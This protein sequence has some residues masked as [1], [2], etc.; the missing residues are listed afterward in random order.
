MWDVDTNKQ[1][2]EMEMKNMIKAANQ[3]SRW[4]LMDVRIVDNYGCGLYHV[5]TTGVLE[6]NTLRGSILS[7]PKLV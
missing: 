7:N 3:F 2:P 4:D 6:N 5:A 1:T